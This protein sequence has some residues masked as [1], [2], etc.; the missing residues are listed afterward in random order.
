[1]RAT[2]RS[3][4]SDS[5]PIFN[6]NDS[7]VSTCCVCVFFLMY[8]QLMNFCTT[9]LTWLYGCVL[10]LCYDADAEQESSDGIPV[11]CTQGRAID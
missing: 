8:S 4:I 9:D 2:K 11:R 10:G 7:F 1:M 3:A 5:T 6:T